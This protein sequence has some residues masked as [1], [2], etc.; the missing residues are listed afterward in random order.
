MRSILSLIYVAYFRPFESNFD[1]NKEIF[2][3]ICIL[4]VSYSLF[5]FTDFSMEIDLKNNFGYILISI[6]IVNILVNGFF[7]VK[8]ILSIVLLKIKLL[9]IY[10]MRR[11]EFHLKSSIIKDLISLLTNS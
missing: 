8:T 2:N 3:E 6:V 10:F 9:K 7:I 5:I 11:Q 4:I 1:N